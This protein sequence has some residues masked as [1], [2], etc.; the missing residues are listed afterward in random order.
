MVDLQQ[1]L[2]FLVTLEG[3]QTPDLAYFK[4]KSYFLGYIGGES[5]SYFRTK[6]LKKNKKAVHRLF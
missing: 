5:K 2:T 4:P 6:L 3:N 1:N